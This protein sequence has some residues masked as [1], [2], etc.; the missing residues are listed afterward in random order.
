MDPHFTAPYC[1]QLLWNNVKQ[2]QLQGDFFIVHRIDVWVHFLIIY[3]K[4]KETA[5]SNVLVHGHITA[6]NLWMSG[7]TLNPDR[8]CR[9]VWRFAVPRIIA[10]PICG[11][12][13]IIVFLKQGERCKYLN[14]KYSHISDSFPS[15]LLA[16]SKWS[17][18]ELKV[19]Q[20]ARLC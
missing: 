4:I 3:Y 18:C 2:L 9:H 15:Y 20:T 1:G 14:W 19:Q 6:V 16:C 17:R 10:H 11:V 8:S 13:V 7:I 12:D 5:F